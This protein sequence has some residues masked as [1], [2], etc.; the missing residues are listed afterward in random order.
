MSKFDLTIQLCSLFCYFKFVAEREKEIAQKKKM[1]LT[2]DEDPDG[3]ALEKIENPLDEAAKFVNSLEKWCGDK[4][5]THLLSFEVFY[6]KK[7]FLRAL[8]ALKKSLDQ[9]TSHH[10]VHYNL[11]QLSLVNGMNCYYYHIIST[12]LFNGFLLCFS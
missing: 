6:K 5:E 8:H 2:V 11:I 10:Q 9:T 4:L 12:F 1:G 3:E 7:K